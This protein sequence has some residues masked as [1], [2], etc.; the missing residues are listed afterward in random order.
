MKSK[1]CSYKKKHK[2]EG[3][4]DERMEEKYV[5]INADKEKEYKYGN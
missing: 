2:N 3:L 4:E 5:I 1:T